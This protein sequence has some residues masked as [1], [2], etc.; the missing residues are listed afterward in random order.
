MI[1]AGLYLNTLNKLNQWKEVI[2]K[3]PPRLPIAEIEVGYQPR[4]IT[5][6]TYDG[7][8]ETFVDRCFHNG[9]LPFSVAEFVYDPKSRQ[10]NQSTNPFLELPLSHKD[11]L[12]FRRKIRD[13]QNMGFLPHTLVTSP[14]SCQIPLDQLFQQSDLIINYEYTGQPIEY[15]VSFVNCAAG[16]GN[17]DQPQIHILAGNPIRTVHHKNR[18]SFDWIQ[19]SPFLHHFGMGVSVEEGTNDFHRFLVS[20]W[21]NRYFKP[22]IQKQ[23]W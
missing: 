23:T 13:A 19:E 10:Y 1:E 15:Q 21:V 2:G 4:Q 14:S 12:P 6:P 11:A 8:I 9:I 16:A 7:Q 3:I 18:S 20:D 22:F 5:F 17:Q